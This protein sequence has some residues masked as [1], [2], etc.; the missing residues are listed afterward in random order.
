MN[1]FIKK[2]IKVKLPVAALSDIRTVFDLNEHEHPVTI[3]NPFQAVGLL[4]NAVNNAGDRLAYAEI[5]GPGEPF[6]NPEETVKTIE[7]IRNKYPELKVTVGTNGLNASFYADKL[8]RLKVSRL[9]MTINAVDAKI[10]SRIYSAVNYNGFVYKGEEG[11]E[12][13]VLS[14]LD[15]IE[16]LLGYRINVRINTILIPGVNDRH[17]GDIEK[18]VKEL[19]IGMIHLKMKVPEDYPSYMTGI[20]PVDERIVI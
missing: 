11:A 12:V 13:L 14:Q 1:T 20:Y 19:G 15:A 17:I 6:A 2:H 8:A 3:L 10:G 18:K 7:L 4:E 5:A 16:K 9:T